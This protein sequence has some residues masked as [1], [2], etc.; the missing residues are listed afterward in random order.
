[1]LDQTTQRLQELLELKELRLH[2]LEKQKAIQGVD[3]RPH[4]NIEIESIKHD[5]SVLRDSVKTLPKNGLPLIKKDSQTTV[6]SKKSALISLAIIL[7]I[8]SLVYF[9]SLTGRGDSIEIDKTSQVIKA[10]TTKDPTDAYYSRLVLSK[11]NDSTVYNL[12]YSLPGIPNHESSLGFFMGGT[13]DITNYNYLD[14]DISL[15]DQQCAVGIAST[16][17]GS[18]P[19]EDVIVG[20]GSYPS[21]INVVI[22]G[23]WQSIRIPIKKHFPSVN[24]KAMTSVFFAF[25]SN[26]SSGEHMISVKNV[27][28]SK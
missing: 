20:S 12:E 22:S 10:Y 2:E 17:D 6:I 11:F 28:L 25:S 5:I 8:I 24:Y 7:S 27:R 26:V 15:S 3:A 9:I 14:F 16:T 13:F 19:T 21:D 18:S 23:D 1:M 4:T